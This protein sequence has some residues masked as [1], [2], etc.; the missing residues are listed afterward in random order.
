M[1]D[2]DQTLASMEVGLQIDENALDQCLV[3]QPDLFWKVAKRHAV[4]ISDRDGAKKNLAEIEA[5]VDVEIR[6]VA[7]NRENRITEKEI[8]S[9]KRKDAQVERATRKLGSVNHEVLL[10]AALKD[11]FEMRSDALKDLVKLF[12]ASYYEESSQDKA[13][14][15]LRNEKVE[16]RRADIAKSY[17]NR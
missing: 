11:A 12:I 16:Q 14:R 8:E 17:A 3:E 6:K 9:I 7:R 1:K 2:F 5:E 10:L 4:A 13:Q 15:G